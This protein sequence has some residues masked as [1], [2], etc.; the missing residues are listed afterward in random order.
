MR[1]IDISQE[2]FTCEVYPGDRAPKAIK[3]SRISDGAIYNLSSFEMCAHN[4]THL[5]APFHFVKDGKTVDNVPL[6]KCVGWCFVAE[7]N[8]EMSEHDAECIISKAK[9]AH[10]EAYRK[11]LIKGEA[12]V[13]EQSAVIFAENGIDLLGVE[14]QTVGPEGEPMKTHLILLE[15]E[16]CLLEG[17]RLGKADEGVYFLNAAPLNLGGF[18]GAPC[19]AVLIG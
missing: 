17:V 15:K 4:G 9:K 5:D 18:D 12:I 19:R 2:V 14:S 3:E 6:D 8:G 7:F 13:T 1:I 10:E 11:I 16:V